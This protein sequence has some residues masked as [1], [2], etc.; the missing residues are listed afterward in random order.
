MCT[1]ADT[2]YKRNNLIIIINHR[3]F[4][5]CTVADAR[6]KRNN[7][8]NSLIIITTHL[9]HRG[10]VRHNRKVAFMNK[11]VDKIKINPT[12]LWTGLGVTQVLTTRGLL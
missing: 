4:Y 2:L 3:C 6:Y 5:M 8:N 12:E 10:S 9:L 7:N 1:V 11:L